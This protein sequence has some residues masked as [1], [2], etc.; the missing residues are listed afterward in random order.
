MANRFFGCN[1]TRGYLRQS[2]EVNNKK[3]VCHLGWVLVGF[4]CGSLI[5]YICASL[6]LLCDSAIIYLRNK[7]KNIIYYTILFPY[8][9]IYTAYI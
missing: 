5:S 1:I 7:H 9:S 3:S 2:G 4:W 6:L 8:I